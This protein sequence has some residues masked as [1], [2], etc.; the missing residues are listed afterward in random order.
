M[1]KFYNETYRK[2][3]AAIQEQEIEIDCLLLRSETIIHLIVNCLSEVKEYVQKRGFK[4]I[5][6][7]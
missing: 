5:C 3:E 6:C 7:N 1:D 2:L 4:N